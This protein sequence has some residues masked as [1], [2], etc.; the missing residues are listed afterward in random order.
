MLKRNIT[1][2]IIFLYYCF[3]CFRN[4]KSLKRTSR[5]KQKLKPLDTQQ[6]CDEE[7]VNFQKNDISTNTGFFAQVPVPKQSEKTEIYLSLTSKSENEGKKRN[8]NRIESNQNTSVVSNE[9][10]LPILK[11]PVEEKQTEKTKTIN[12][13]KIKLCNYCNTP[14]LKDS[15]PITYPH[16][17]VKDAMDY[18]TWSHKYKSLHED[19]CKKLNLDKNDVNDEDFNKFSYSVLSLPDCI[20][21]GESKDDI[22]IF[23]KIDLEPFSQFGPL[24]GKVVKEMDIPEDVDMKN[25]WEVSEN[26]RNVYFNTEDALVSNWIRYIRPAP[27]RED[28]NLT[29]IAR[30]YKMYFVS[31]EFIKA[32][33]ELLYWQ[34]CP[35]LGTKKKMEKI[36]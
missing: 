25:I 4:Q 10:T 27:K 22:G 8:V 6:N 13:I 32:G 34:D 16:Y 5:T 28:R 26:N 31:V 12:V 15:C 18:N 33:D 1:G 14:H 11:E 36:G 30:D 29:V 35:T 20:C 9:Q 17:T 7:N 2:Y 19:H 3:V 24:V 23:A 21:L